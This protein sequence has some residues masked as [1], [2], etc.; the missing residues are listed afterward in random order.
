[1]QGTHVRLG[2]CD[3]CKKKKKSL[4]CLHCDQQECASC[5]L[6]RISAKE[7]MAAD[8]LNE[9]KGEINSNRK[10]WNLECIPKP[11]HEQSQGRVF[12]AELSNSM[13]IR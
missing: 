1:M 4:N 5:T 9:N 3:P 8:K 12:A 6:I 13:E 10:L 11:V 7:E 2:L